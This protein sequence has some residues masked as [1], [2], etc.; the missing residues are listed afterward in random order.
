[1]A[2]V[3]CVTPHLVGILHVALELGRRLE[4]DG[5]RVSFCAPTSAAETVGGYGRDLALS[6]DSTTALHDFLEGDAERPWLERLR[7]RASRL[8]DAARATGVLEWAA[9]V[10]KLA[11]DLVLID[12]ELAEQIVALSGRGQKLAL[13]NGFG[14][15]WR[16]PGLTPTHR[17]VRPGVGFAGTRLGRGLLWSDLVWRKR[18]RAL[19]LR[20]RSLGVDRLSRLEWL[21]GEVG[22][23]WRAEA[24]DGH[25]LRPVT[26]PHLPV[27]NPRALEFDFP[28]R[29]LDTVHYVGPL[30]PESRPGEDLSDEDRRTLDEVFARRQAGDR[31]IYAAF[32]S[33]F[34]ADA[35]RIQAMVK[36]LRPGWRL[37]LTGGGVSG[38]LGTGFPE[39]VHV[40]SWAPQLEVLRQTDVAITHGGIHTVDECVLAGVPQ[41]VACGWKTDMAGNTARLVHHGLGLELRS[42]DGPDQIRRHLD[43]LLEEPAFRETAASF[44]E[45]YRAYE[46]DR[47]LETVVRLLVGEETA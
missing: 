26:F 15:V 46:R 6:F 30:V 21:A 22:M 5:H 42:D 40:V 4:A 28:H 16:R 3:L 29:P 10:E 11:P 2:H 23:D 31:L 19:R 39:N 8:E 9:E 44:S 45:S 12:A 38:D 1:M 14:S 27:V 34:T 36:A 13:L 41:L 17:N 20:V 25:W 7:R 33:F 18:A 47:V 43:R 32:G 37:L 24:D 35:A